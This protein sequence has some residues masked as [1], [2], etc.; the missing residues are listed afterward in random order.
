V[1][2]RGN[3]TKIYYRVVNV[4]VDVVLLLLEMVVLLGLGATV[5]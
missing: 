1:L 2:G 4:N 3:L 5:M